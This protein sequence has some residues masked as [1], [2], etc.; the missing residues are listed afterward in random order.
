MAEIVLTADPFKQHISQ[1]PE[2]DYEKEGFAYLEENSYIIWDE[3]PRKAFDNW[4][5]EDKR[6]WVIDFDLLTEPVIS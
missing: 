6:Y 1:M 5:Q 4:K 2:E 3:G